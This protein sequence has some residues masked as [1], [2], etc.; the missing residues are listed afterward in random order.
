MGLFFL[1]VIEETKEIRSEIYKVGENLPLLTSLTHTSFHARMHTLRWTDGRTKPA[2][3]AEN[4][5]F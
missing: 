5:T 2:A 4:C 1:A 3:E